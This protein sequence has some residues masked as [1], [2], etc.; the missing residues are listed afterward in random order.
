MKYKCEL[1]TNKD[2]CH[3]ISDNL[4]EIR[5]KNKDS[6]NQRKKY[7]AM[8]RHLGKRGYNYPQVKI[9][10]EK[11][12]WFSTKPIFLDFYLRQIERIFSL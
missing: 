10:S 11:T 7:K 12:C 8:M 4:M 5:I 3:K 6:E 1:C 9:Q 2:T